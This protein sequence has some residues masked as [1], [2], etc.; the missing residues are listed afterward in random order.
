MIL[1]W[2]NKETKREKESEPQTDR[3]SKEKAEGG[4]YDE[5]Y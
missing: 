5:M 1:D 2:S 3:A 4:D